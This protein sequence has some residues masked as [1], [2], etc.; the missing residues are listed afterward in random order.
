L[1]SDASAQRAAYEALF[2]E[3]LKPSSLA[4]IRGA[5]NAGYPLASGSFKACLS[6]G[7]SRRL[8]PGRPGRPSKESSDDRDSQSPTLLP[9]IA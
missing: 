1:G 8:E 5:T 7:T 4:E 6:D 9:E 3:D 2:D